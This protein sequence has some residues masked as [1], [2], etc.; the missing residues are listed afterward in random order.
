V[1]TFSQKVDNGPTF[2]TTLEMVETEVGQFAPSK[3]ATEQHGNDCSVALSLERFG[4]GR[5]P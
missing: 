3:T 1:A 5:L 4:I 2:L